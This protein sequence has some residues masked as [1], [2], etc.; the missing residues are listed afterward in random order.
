[1]REKRSTLRLHLTACGTLAPDWCPGS[2]DGGE[3]G[4]KAKAQ[5]RSE[6]QKHE[7]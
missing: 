5:K 1:M 7:F 4:R 3:A 2:H 6:C